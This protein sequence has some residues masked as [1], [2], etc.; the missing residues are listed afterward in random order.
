MA[1]NYTYSKERGY[2]GIGIYGAKFESNAGVLWRAS[3]NLGADY[4]FTIGARYQ[5]TRTDTLKS[6]AHTPLFEYDEFSQFFVPKASR[7]IA[8]EIVPEAQNLLDF[9]HPER[10]T[11]LLGAEDSGLPPEVLE[12]ADDIIQ[13]PSTHCLN[14][15]MTGVVIMWDRIMKGKLSEKNTETKN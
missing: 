14:V 4:T 1:E 2:F 8:A 3:T 15:S 12:R 10:A 9:K 6:Y 13:I 11:Y 7:L 5:R